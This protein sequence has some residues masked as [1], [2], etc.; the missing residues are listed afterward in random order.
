MNYYPFHLGDYISATRH[1]SWDEDMA[2]RRLLDAY[3][4]REEALPLDRAQVYRLVC[5]TTPEQRTAVDSVLREFFEETAWG[6]VNAR[7]DEVITEI[8]MKRQKAAQSAKARWA[9]ADAVRTHSERSANA[10]PT[11]CEGNAPNTNTNTN[12][13]PNTKEKQKPTPSVLAGFDEFW[14]AYPNRQA[15][16]AA[17]KAFAKLSPDSVLLEVM[18]AS[19]AK[20]RRSE[21]WSKD[22][23]RFIPYPATWLNQRRWEDDPPA[24]RGAPSAGYLNETHDDLLAALQRQSG[25]V[26]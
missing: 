24:A 1:L 5:A 18:L 7:C 2:Y 15:K 22:G 10:V 16:Q 11:Q 13:K 20:W 17:Q 12:T 19:I 3:Y 21:S 26:Q 23:G 8:A 14:S 6:W 25:E 9:D 4:T